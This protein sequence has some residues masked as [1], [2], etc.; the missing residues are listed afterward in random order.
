MP[1]HGTARRS[2]I[3]HD[4]VLLHDTSRNGTTRYRTTRYNATRDG[5]ARHDMTRYSTI[6]CTTRRSRY[7][8]MAV[9]GITRFCTTVHGTARHLKTR[10]DTVLPTIRIYT[11]RYDTVGHSMPRRELQSLGAESMLI[12][13]GGSRL[14]CRIRSGCRSVRTTVSQC[15]LPKLALLPKRGL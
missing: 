4:T 12:R 5:T 7:Y 8:G 9:H 3:Q 14:P 2:T 6:F 13:K 11:I 15:G 1:R 10:Y